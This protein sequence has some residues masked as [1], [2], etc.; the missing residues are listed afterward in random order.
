MGDNHTP[1]AQHHFIPFTPPILFH[2]NAPKCLTLFFFQ[3]TVILVFPCITPHATLYF[4][5]VAFFRLRSWFAYFLFFIFHWSH[6]V[7]SCH[8]GLSQ[9]RLKSVT[10]A[11]FERCRAL[12]L[13]DR[14]SLTATRTARAPPAGDHHPRRRTWRWGWHR[15]SR[16]HHHQR[17]GRPP[18]DRRPRS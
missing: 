9:L 16:G 13:V 10:I 15:Q 11:Q 5:F 14:W 8:K 18:R 7:Q 17:S 4:F 6:G 12:A 2:P 1:R 3:I